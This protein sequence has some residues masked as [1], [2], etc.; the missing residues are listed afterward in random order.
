M[1]HK[2]VYEMNKS[3]AQNIHDVLTKYMDEHNYDSAAAFVHDFNE[4]VPDAPVAESTFR[5][6]LH[7]Q[8]LPNLYY[9]VRLSE[10]MDI[11]LY[12]LIYN[13]RLEGEDA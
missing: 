9:L 12:D 7:Q 4:L 3:Y 5:N 6:W 2:A 13:Y 1:I 11:D 10:F 8:S